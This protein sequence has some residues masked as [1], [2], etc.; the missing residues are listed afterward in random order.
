MTIE[1]LVEDRMQ[2][3]AEMASQ[4]DREAEQGAPRNSSY[5]LGYMTSTIKAAMYMATHLADEPVEDDDWYC[6]ICDG[7]CFSG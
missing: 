5:T 2:A 7:E 3:L 6:E 4:L 1:E